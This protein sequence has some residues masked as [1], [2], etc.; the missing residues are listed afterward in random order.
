M[1]KGDRGDLLRVEV[2][3]KPSERLRMHCTT[4]SEVNRVDFHEL[5]ELRT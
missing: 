5:G 3:R 2:E 1:T 4:A